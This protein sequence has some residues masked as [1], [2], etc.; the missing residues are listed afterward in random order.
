MHRTCDYSALLQHTRET[1]RTGAA[2]HSTLDGLQD[3]RDTPAG[4]LK[5][6]L[7]REVRVRSPPRARAEGA[8]SWWF[9]VGGVCNRVLAC[10]QAARFLHSLIARPCRS[11]FI[12][13]FRTGTDERIGGT[14]EGDR[15][16]TS[17]KLGPSVAPPPMQ[18]EEARGSGQ[19]HHAGRRL[20]S[21]GSR[22]DDDEEASSEGSDPRRFDSQP[23][24]QQPHR[25]RRR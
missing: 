25:W 14:V 18:T 8:V 12:S 22:T 1:A 7:L 2:D 21:G 16:R 11:L 4:G 23:A 19:W 6:P 17:F 9:L 13:Y 3:S 24:H 5:P 20:G 15:C 10:G